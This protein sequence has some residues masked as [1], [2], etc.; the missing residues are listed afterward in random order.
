MSAD[1]LATAI[2]TKGVTDNTFNTAIGGSG[3]VA[4]RFK[5]EGFTKDDVPTK[6]YA[7]FRIIAMAENDTLRKN[8]ERALIQIKVYSDEADGGSEADQIVQ[9][10]FDLFQKTALTTTGYIR[11][12]LF[13][14]NRIPAYREEDFWT[15]VIDFRTFIQEN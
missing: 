1:P 6:P 15:S 13:R 10:A 9:K 4:G 14:E 3:T 2:Y 8:L 12:K 7:T 11:V 5:P